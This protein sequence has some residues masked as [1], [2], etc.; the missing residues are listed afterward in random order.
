M[1]FA[2]FEISKFYVFACNFFQIKYSYNGNLRRYY[3]TI[4]MLLDYTYFYVIDIFLIT[5]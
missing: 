2:L 4:Y 5:S 3:Y 1:R